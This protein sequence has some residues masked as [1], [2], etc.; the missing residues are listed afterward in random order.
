MAKKIYSTRSTNIKKIL[1]IFLQA[2]KMYGLTKMDF[3]P[4]NPAPLYFLTTLCLK[5]KGFLRK[6]AF[7]PNSVTKEFKEDRFEK[8]FEINLNVLVL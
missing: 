7:G 2:S 3:I 5:F 4:V 8:D 1:F 6:R